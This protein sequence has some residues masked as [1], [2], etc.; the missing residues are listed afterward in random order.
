MAKLITFQHCSKQFGDKMVLDN[1]SFSIN[2]KDSFISILGKSGCG[3]TTLICLL[4]GL[5][6]LQSGAIFIREEKVSEGERIIVSPHL[7]NMGFIFQ[8][9]AL[10]P[11]FT[12]F[13][14]IAF[15]LRLKKVKDYQRIV[16]EILNQFNILSLKN[17]FPNQLSGGQQQLVA[18]ARNLVLNPKIL[19]MDEP[20]ANL[21]VKLKTQI[22]HLLKQIIG[23]KNITVIYI[24]HDHK[25]AIELSDKI[26][27]LNQG[28]TE[29]Y[30]T[31][32][33]MQQE[34]N[35]FVKEFIEF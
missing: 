24:T 3:K 1:V 19:L 2:E 20:L 10:F 17:N 35:T 4:A 13:E 6:Q 11:H 27:L 33:E 26:L 32:K 14:N 9:L 12:V 18:L 16:E 29:F 23:E 7:R 34:N 21:D 30:G 8:D 22:R 25:E 28:K 15:G 31:P 5:E